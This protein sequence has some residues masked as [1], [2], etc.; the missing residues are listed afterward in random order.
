LIEAFLR[1]RT[2]TTP[3][4]MMDVNVEGYKICKPLRQGVEDKNDEINS[5]EN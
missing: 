5:Y 2:I 4:H 1:E 3:L